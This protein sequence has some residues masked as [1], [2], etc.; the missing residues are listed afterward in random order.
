MVVEKLVRSNAF[1]FL[2]VEDLVLEDAKNV[3]NDGERS[4]F[5]IL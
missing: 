4:V 5:C 1:L 3:S 2:V